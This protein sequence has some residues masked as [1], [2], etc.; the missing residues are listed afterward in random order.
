MKVMETARAM[1]LSGVLSLG[2]APAFAHHSFAMFDSQK[3]VAVD[4]TVKEFQWTNPHSWIQ[5]VVKD[6]ATG[7]EAEWSVELGSPNALEREGFR[8]TSF[9]PGDQ[10]HVVIHPLKDGSNG[11]SFVS[12]MVNGVQ[13]GGAHS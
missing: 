1:A 9:K 2:A 6:P 7:K 4:G 12:A 5:L 13:I 8:R 10:A 11:G 3:N